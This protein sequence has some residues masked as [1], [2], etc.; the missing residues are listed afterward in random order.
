MA[1]GSRYWYQVRAIE[2][3]GPSYYIGPAYCTTLPIQTLTAT[4][5][6]TGEIDLAFGNISAQPGALLEVDRST[7]GTNFTPLTSTLAAGSTSY[8][9]TDAALVEGAHYWYRARAMESPTA[10][11]YTD[12]ADTWTLALAPSGLAATVA[13]ANE[14]D[15]L[16]TNNS[17]GSPQ[18]AILRSEDGV[19]FD[20][21]DVVSAGTTT[22]A[23]TSAADGTAH[24]YQ[25]AAMNPGGSSAASNSVPAQTPLLVPFSLTA[26]VFNS[27][28]IDVSWSDASATTATG[29]N[30][31]RSTDDVTFAQVGSTTGV[32]ASYFSDT[33]LLPGTH[34]YYEIQA[35]NAVVTSASSKPADAI[36]DPTLADSGPSSVAEGSTY[37]L[38]LTANHDPSIPDP[39][40]GWDITWGDG[41]NQHVTGDPGSVGH[42]YTEPGS[43]PAV[44][45]S[46]GFTG[47]TSNQTAIVIE[48]S[49][50]LAVSGTDSV[51]ENTTYTLNATYADPGGDHV[52]EW[53]ITWGDGQTTDMP[54]SN[55][56]VDTAGA[57][58][59]TQSFTHQYAHGDATYILGA[60]ALTDD[61]LTTTSKSVQVINSDPNFNPGQ[62]NNYVSEDGTYALHISPALDG[63]AH[64]P[65]T[66]DI[67]WG[68]GTADTTCQGSSDGMSVPTQYHQYLEE[69]WRL[70]T[71]TPSYGSVQNKYVGTA[72]S[73]PTIAAPPEQAVASGQSLTIN[74]SFTGGATSDQWAAFIDLHDGTGPHA[75]TASGSASG[76]LAFN[77]PAPIAPGSY[78][79]TITLYDKGG[80]AAAVS[81]FTLDVW[82]AVIDKGEAN[83]LLLASSDGTQNPQPVTFY[84]PHPAGVGLTVTFGT[85]DAA[86]DYLWPTDSPVPGS[87]PLIGGNSTSYSLS[88]APSVSSATYWV[89]AIN[90][91]TKANVLQFKLSGQVTGTPP[92]LPPGTQPVPVTQPVVSGPASDGQLQI[93]AE[94]NPNGG[95][96]GADVG[97]V[98]RNWMV[99]QMVDLKANFLAPGGFPSAAKFHWGVPISGGVLHNY[100]PTITPTIS[101]PLRTDNGLAVLPNNGVSSTHNGLSQIEVIFFWTST[102]DLVN[103][104]TNPVSLSVSGIGTRTTTFKIFEPTV[105]NTSLKVGTAGIANGNWANVGLLRGARDP[106][107]VD[108][109]VVAIANVSVPTGF[110]PGVFNFLQLLHGTDTYFEAKDSTAYKS[111]FPASE[112]VLDLVWPLNQ[113]FE[114]PFNSQ[115]G[116]ATGATHSWIDAPSAPTGT[117]TSLTVNSA[118]SLYIM[119][120]PPGQSV[121]WVS[122]QIATWG[123]QLG[124]VDK[125]FPTG[126]TY[127][128]KPTDYGNKAANQFR[129]VTPEP[130]WTN[131]WNP[132]TVFVKG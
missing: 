55:P 66:Y 87:I 21:I 116:W 31:L 78:Q 77:L 15:L 46:D 32:N 6:S 75:G 83:D 54:V 40:T 39:V 107:N 68:D 85:T 24:T 29:Y 33:S 13:G 2:P 117:K 35:T 41:S 14:V 96:L 127:S 94:S 71:V 53:L 11:G 76:S 108:W 49:A 92:Q 45:S 4:A 58:T 27:S 121:C 95:Q 70:V 112:D 131:V 125:G 56:P 69:G 61:D 3:G 122:L 84:F 30:V 86:D 9:D 1:E 44:T 37:T 16:W 22:Y 19:N 63:G 111:R 113:K 43:Y 98:A 104:D 60:Q 103:P 101:T 79:P 52:K 17:A 7:D 72:D 36:T 97:D 129:V 109:G 12:P 123:Y 47:L 110:A 115:D 124:V 62:D 81:T 65:V 128:S 51:N 93:L 67:Q 120:R 74:A 80:T 8:N 90:G 99:G 28:E 82:G 130:S 50:N 106:K 64:D 126:Y 5:V 132:L 42:I 25:V 73:T 38:M 59:D 89:G 100:N 114:D 34:Y 91:N 23:D 105:S 102:K 10:S 118:F 119:F 57:S 18:T 48:A 88:E 20:T 26:S